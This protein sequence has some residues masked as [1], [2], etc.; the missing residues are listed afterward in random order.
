MKP[1]MTSGGRYSERT[2]MA[3]R[4]LRCTL[5]FGVRGNFVDEDDLPGDLV[6]SETFGGEGLD[7][8]GIDRCRV[9]A[10]HERADHRNVAADA[11]FGAR[12]FRDARHAAS[13]AS[14]SSGDTR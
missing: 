14:I 3:V 13:A 4:A 8:I 1:R 9:V 11:D 6:G 5:P 12:D 10:D 7:G 2:A